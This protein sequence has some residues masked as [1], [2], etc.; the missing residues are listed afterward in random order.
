MYSYLND[1]DCPFFT[2]AKSY[3]QG[4]HIR[5]LGS[6]LAEQETLSEGVIA[7]IDG[8]ELLLD[9][10]VLPGNSGSAV[11]NDA[12]ELVGTAKAVAIAVLS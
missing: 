2:F 12:G 7:K 6:P 8:D 5:V 3:K 9:C 10:S 1:Q 4:E 11:F